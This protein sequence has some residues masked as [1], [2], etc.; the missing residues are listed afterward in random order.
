[1]DLISIYSKDEI[2]P[3]WEIIEERFPS[4]SKMIDKD[5]KGRYR[6]IINKQYINE[7]CQIF[8]RWLHRKIW[9]SKWLHIIRNNYNFTPKEE[10]NILKLITECIYKN[11]PELTNLIY[12]KAMIMFSFNLIHLEGFTIFSLQEYYEELLNQTEE[13]IEQYYIEQEYKEILNLLQYYIEVEGY[14]FGTLN[15]VATCDGK[16]NYF[17]NHFQ[18]ITKQCITMIQCDPYTVE[19]TADDCLVTILITMMPERIKIY[20]SRNIEDKRIIDTLKRIF[21]KRIEIFPETLELI[22]K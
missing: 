20:G 16:Y 18:N 2:L 8:S 10:E 22:K 15:V 21:G 17:N 1:M 6:L 9:R 11:E 19:S 13:I 7:F 4:Q 12:E 5:Q 3:L 14:R